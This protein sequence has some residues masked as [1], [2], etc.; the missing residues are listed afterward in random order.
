MFP[1]TILFVSGRDL[2]VENSVRSESLF[3]SAWVRRATALV[4]SRLPLR[5]TNAIKTPSAI[6]ARKMPAARCTDEIVSPAKNYCQ[7]SDDSL[8]AG[9]G[10]EV[11][12]GDRPAC[13]NTTIFSGLFST[14]ARRAK[15]ALGLEHFRFSA[16]RRASI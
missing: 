2:S 9:A 5:K 15:V 13:A 8:L 16:R 14:T 4:P 6:P 10:F 7:F 12:N 1:R 3:A 11:M